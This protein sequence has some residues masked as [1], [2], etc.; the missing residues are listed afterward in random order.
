M[1]SVANALVG[2]R[3]SAHDVASKSDG[4]L[5]SNRITELGESRDGVVYST[6]AM[7]AIERELCTV[8]KRLAAGKV[9]SPDRVIVRRLTNQ[10]GL[11]QEQVAIVEAAT[12]GLRLTL[13]QGGAG[14]GKSTALKAIT[15]AWQ[16]AG[17]TVVGAAVAWRAAHILRDDLAIEARA[18]DS[19][20]AL[21]EVGDRVFGHKHCLIIEE[22]GL[23]SSRQAL[24]LIQAIEDAG[25]VCILVGDENQ[26]KPIGA[27]HAMRIVREAVGASEISQVV[28]Q[29][30]EWARQ[31]PTDFARGD[32]EKALA[33]FEDRGLI[34][35]EQTAKAAALRLVREWDEVRRASTKLSS[36]IIAKTN[37]EVR[38]LA[39]AVRTVLR[40]NNVLQGPDYPLPA[41]DASGNG[42]TLN[43]A[44]GDRIR[45]LVR[46]DRLGIVNGSEAEIIDIHLAAG[47]KNL[48]VTARK[49]RETI[50]FDT[51]DLS[52]QKG[53]VK[54]A[55]AYATTL[56]QAQGITVDK[57][58]VLLSSRFDR[59][60][61]YVASSR[62]RETT[63]FFLDERSLASELTEN[64][65]DRGSDPPRAL[66]IEHLAKRLA[67]TSVK[68]T[69]L[70]LLTQPQD[71]VEEKAHRREF[72][73]EL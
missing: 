24:R 64:Q 53:R 22:A 27:G 8:A 55:I 56:F 68:T 59:H 38:A 72:E 9:S 66:L 49:D 2:T 48:C 34:R 25:G 23:Q 40:S 17:Y 30:A 31:A 52:D 44:K 45:F 51:A 35:I 69:T 54:L 43:L 13:V 3:I 70:D 62:A 71:R 6:P 65:S 4:L 15:E 37:A 18:I 46:D 63:T 29:H 10:H 20:V 16:S 21:S 73:H 61:A 57:A 33:A 1:E 26:L 14:T 42:Y 32:A 28:R 36:T 67:R 50:I 12:A 11:N 58:F 41:V 39:S 47:S 60:D 5:T 19:W 7:I